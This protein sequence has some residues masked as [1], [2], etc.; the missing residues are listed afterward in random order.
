MYEYFSKGCFSFRKTN[1]QFSQIGL[2]QVHEQNNAVIKGSGGAT[3]LLNKVDESALLRWEVCNP[4]LARLL[5]EFEDAMDCNAQVETLDAKHHEDNDNFR[6]Q[7][8]ADVK[9]L[10]KGFA[11]N[12]FLEDKLKRVNNSKIFFPDKTVEALKCM[13]TKGEKD[14]VGFITDRLV[15]GTV[16]VCEE[17]KKNEYDLWNESTSKKEKI[18]YMPSKSAFNKMKSACEYRL[19]MA[20]E[21]FDGEVMNVPQSLTPDGVSLYHGTKSDI[22]KRFDSHESIPE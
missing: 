21:L 9:A 5:L 3:D 17:I 8:S 14:V 1:R 15:L 19:D 12:P 10:C 22:A 18:P 13:E 20:L 2:D 16:S 7:F 4:E 6:K 11:M